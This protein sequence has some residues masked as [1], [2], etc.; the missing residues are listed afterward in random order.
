MLINRGKIDGAQPVD[1][2]RSPFDFHLPICLTGVLREA[3]RH[4]LGHGVAPSDF[5]TQSLKAHRRLSIL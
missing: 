1:A 2:G 5:F 3:S 4:L